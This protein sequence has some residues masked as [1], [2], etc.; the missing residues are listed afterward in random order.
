MSFI[1]PI[2]SY[3][4]CNSLVLI[5]LKREISIAAIKGILPVDGSVFNA[6]DETRIFDF[7]AMKRE[8]FTGAHM[9]NTPE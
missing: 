4:P 2:T 1:K 7:C 9:D 5:G 6:H 8:I 3:K